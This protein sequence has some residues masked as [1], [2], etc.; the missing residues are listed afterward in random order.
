MKEN[1]DETKAEETH[2]VETNEV[3]NEDEDNDENTMS[4]YDKFNRSELDAFSALVDVDD[5]IY[6]E[7]LKAHA[8]H[9][10]FFSVFSREENDGINYLSPKGICLKTKN[11][12]FDQFKQEMA[13]HEG[14]DNCEIILAGASELIFAL[15]T[16]ICAL[17]IGHEDS[18][19]AATK[20]IALAINDNLYKMSKGLFELMT[21]E[22]M[23]V[24]AQAY[25]EG[26]PLKLATMMARPGHHKIP[27][28][29]DVPFSKD[30]EEGNK[31]HNAKQPKIISI[32]SNSEQ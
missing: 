20:M 32:Q 19:P 8:E 12:N 22:Q 16:M 11:V 9:H 6:M 26:L 24:G 5:D 2:T 29:K 10:D 18:E 30:S 15:K 31:V 7:R 1:K 27:F 4:E 21:C 28:Y 17:L 13:S 3:D 23:E 25:I 14:N